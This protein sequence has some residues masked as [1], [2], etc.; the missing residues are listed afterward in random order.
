MPA[1]NVAGTVESQLNRASPANADAQLGTLLR[2]LIT[3]HNALL[4]KLD[5]DGGV[6]DTNY[7]ATLKVKD[8]ESRAT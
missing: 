7:N 6:T 3:S 5:A 4:A 1:I 8:L 2:E